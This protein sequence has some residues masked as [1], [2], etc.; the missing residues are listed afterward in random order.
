LK[1]IFYR[2]TMQLCADILRILANFRSNQSSGCTAS[3]SEVSNGK[4]I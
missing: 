4:D 3:R 2:K 1:I